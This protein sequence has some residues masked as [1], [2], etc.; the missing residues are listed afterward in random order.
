MPKTYDEAS[1]EAGKT[2]FSGGGSTSDYPE[3]WPEEMLEADL[4]N[5]V[6]LGSNVIRIGEFAW[7][8][9]EPEEGKYD[10]TY[11]DHVIDKAKEKKL[12]IIFGTPTATMPAWLAKKYPEVLSEF[13]NGQKRVFGGRRQYCFN[14]K[15]YQ[16]MSLR[17]VNKLVENY[18]NEDAII[19]WQIDNEF[20]HE[21]S[22]ECFCSECLNAFQDF[23]KHKYEN[24]IQQLNETYGTKFWSQEYNDFTEIPLPKPTITTHNPSL[25]MDYELFRSE[26]IEKFAK[27]QYECIK[28][29]VPH[30]TVIHD[31]PGGGLN[32]HC[33]YSKVAKAGMDIVAYNNYPV[34][35]GQ[36]EPIKPYE[37]AFVLDYMRGLKQQNFWITEAI[38]GAQGHDVTGY[39]PRPNQAKLWSYQG[40]AHGCESLLYFRYRGFTKGAEQFCYGILDA[41]NQKKRR[42]EET[43]SFFHDV[44][45]YKEFWEQPVKSKVCILYDY[46]SAAAFRIQKQSILMNYEEQLKQFYQPL[47][48]RNVSVDVLP[49]EAD[50]MCYDVVI[51]PSMIVWTEERNIRMK[52][53][54]QKGGHLILSFRHGVKD[55]NNNLTLNEELPVRSTDLIGAAV[56]ETESLQDYEA[57]ELKGQYKMD[58]VQGRGGVFRDM[59]KI[60]DAKVL[61]SYTDHFYK[62]YAAVVE[63][64]FGAGQVYY[65]GCH[66]EQKLMLALIDYVLKNAGVETID[67][68]QGVEVF[69][70]TMTKRIL[71]VVMNHNEYP[72]QYGCLKLEPFECTFCEQ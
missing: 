72:V 7:H 60:N 24:N 2:I 31:F 51:A 46:Q 59:L 28:A 9:M 52:E 63:N 42:Y 23:L 30:A 54:V 43:K 38:M 71:K 64:S 27:L 48:E 57:F 26:S 62:E 35:G 68:P 66:M 14:S 53:Y 58:S 19:A 36:K 50:F 32:K 29:I 61:F 4:E 18:K 8:M 47:F 12:S 41:D 6:D 67:S 33:D 45:K 22:D 44:K 37:I 40:M 56:W 20:G 34:W 65:V 69:T 25:R 10:F 49:I 5:I 55:A 21:G 11:F 1:C 16:E 3:Q 17:I 39:L 70:R 15:K 13:E